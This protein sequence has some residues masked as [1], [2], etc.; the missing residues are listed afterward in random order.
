MV[1]SKNHTVSWE[2]LRQSPKSGKIKMRGERCLEQ[3]KKRDRKI[4]I[5]D[6]A[7]DK[8]PFVDVPELAQTECEAIACAHKTLLRAAKEHNNSDEVLFVCTLDQMCKAL[9]MGDE[10]SVDIQKSPEACGILMSARKKNVAL[11]H[12]HP[13]TNKF[14]LSD[15]FVFLRYA[16]ISTLSVVTNQGAVYIL[17]KTSDFDYQK[18]V[19][20]LKQLYDRYH[21]EGLCHDDAVQIFLQECGKGGISYVKS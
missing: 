1:S 17:H 5:T 10:H 6:I 16:Q 15:I 3:A 9:V 13:S 11:L 20:L 4:M 8:V 7:I 21:T 2:A 19:G 18:T 14:S 12:N